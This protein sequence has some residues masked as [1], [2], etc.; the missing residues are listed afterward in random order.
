LVPS[1]ERVRFVG[2][3][4]EATLMAI[5]LA[6]MYTSR[7]KLLKFSGHFHGWHDSVM[8]GAYSP[9]DGSAV[10]GIPADVSE[11]TIVIRPNDL[12]MLE[13]TLT[14]NLDIAAVILEPTGGHWGAVP[15]RGPFLKA[16]RELTLKH[17]QL[18]VFDE[19]ITGFRVA[20]GGAQSYY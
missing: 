9:Y 7:P 18:L 2:S 14:T 8:P 10:P 1:A 4:T 12:A 13:R 3:G 6:R 11:N 15:I 19:V 16:L 17:G 5:R 20:P